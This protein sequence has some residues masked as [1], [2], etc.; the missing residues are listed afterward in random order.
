MQKEFGAFRNRDTFVVSDTEQ[1]PMD[2]IDCKTLRVALASFKPKRP[3]A[4]C[5]D[6]GWCLGFPLMHREFITYLKR[7][8]DAEHDAFF[9]PERMVE[10]FRASVPV[11][12]AK[13]SELS[14]AVMNG[15]HR[16][17]PIKGG[18]IYFLECSNGL[19][20][21]G[22]AST[23]AQA[24]ARWAEKHFGIKAKVASS[25]PVTCC[26]KAEQMIHGYFGRFRTPVTGVIR[27]YSGSL[28]EG[29]EFFSITTD[30]VME[31]VDR[32]VGHK[33]PSTTAR[34]DRRTERV[35]QEALARIS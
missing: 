15:Q 23:S 31:V 35:M 10:W 33:N 2:P 20:K 9:G 22:R 25:I 24:R 32:I 34:Y 29:V 17:E 14:I 4:L 18:V 11:P 16:C 12:V 6:G 7:L 26:V 8:H 1:P 19:I 13:R 28:N 5:P 30:Q 27:S 21:I 3:V